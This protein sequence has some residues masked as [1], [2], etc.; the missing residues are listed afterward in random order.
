MEFLRVNELTHCN[1]SMHR[2]EEGASILTPG[3]SPDADWSDENF[4]ESGKMV[5]D[6]IRHWHEHNYSGA[7]R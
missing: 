3:S 5:R 6:I 2:K 7:D 1:W 4:S